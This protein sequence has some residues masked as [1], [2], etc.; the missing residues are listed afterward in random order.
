MGTT[1]SVVQILRDLGL[2]VASSLGFC[3]ALIYNFIGSIGRLFYYAIISQIYSLFHTFFWS[4]CYIIVSNSVQLVLLPVNIPLRILA[5][6]SMQKI[7]GS[8]NSWTNG[9]VLTTM[10][11]YALVLMIFGVV[12]GTTCGVSLGKVH[13]IIKVP[14]VVIDIP[15][16]FWVRIPSF[17]KKFVFRLLPFRSIQPERYTDE[18]VKMP[19]P[20]PSIPPSDILEPLFADI[21]V[22]PSSRFDDTVWRRQSTSSKASV[23]EMAS[24]LPSDFFQQKYT[25]TDIKTEQA[26]QQA[27][28]QARQHYQSPAASPQHLTREDSSHSSTNIWDRY[29][30]LPSTLRTEGGMSTLYSRRPYTFTKKGERD[31]VSKLKRSN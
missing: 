19:T 10:S 3:A 5:G 29:D 6:T 9:Y 17:V 2:L 7:I 11:Q 25:T 21:P 23:L 28:A 27:R 18:G 14:S 15:I 31:Q 26:R 4:P 16:L 20:S 8:A 22:T 1:T 13:S 30:E 24:K 12:L